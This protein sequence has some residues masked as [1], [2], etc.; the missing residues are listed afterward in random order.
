MC[1]VPRRA[2]FTD[3][4]GFWQCQGEHTGF[5]SWLSPH[6]FPLVLVSSC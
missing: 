2:K 5:S 4:Y 6:G 1:W 3:K